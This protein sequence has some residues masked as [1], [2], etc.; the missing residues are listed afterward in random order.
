MGYVT[1]GCAVVVVVGLLDSIVVG[2][3]GRFTI[4]P[5]SPGGPALCLVCKPSTTTVDGIGGGGGAV[6]A[7]SAAGAHHGLFV[8]RNSGWESG[9]R[10]VGHMIRGQMEKSR[11]A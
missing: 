7:S 5:R 2:I 9:P 8:R 1:G 4:T 3:G 10:S 6:A 11:W